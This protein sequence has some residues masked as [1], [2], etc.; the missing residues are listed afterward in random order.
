MEDWLLL[1]DEALARIRRQGFSEG[2]ALW[3]CVVTGPKRSV[4]QGDYVGEAC[5]SG[6]SER[7]DAFETTGGQL[8]P[9]SRVSHVMPFA[10]PPPPKEGAG[11]CPGKSRFIVAEHWGHNFVG[12]LENITRWAYDRVEEKPVYAEIQANGM[13]SALT[14]SAMKDLTESIHNNAADGSPQDFDLEEVDA[15][16]S[17][18]TEALEG[19]ADVAVARGRLAEGDSGAGKLVRGAELM[20]LMRALA[21]GHTDGVASMNSAGVPAAVARLVPKAKP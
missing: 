8:I 3:L 6:S 2:G 1:N 13:W 17:W 18:V 9:V 20:K 12:K 21:S 7:F 5:G 19:A 4:I 16:P 15:L 10:P 14:E 11:T